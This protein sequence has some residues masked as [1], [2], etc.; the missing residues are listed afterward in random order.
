MHFL[1]QLIIQLYLQNYQELLI[2]YPHGVLS[3]VNYFFNILF[4]SIFI[5]IYCFFYQ[6]ALFSLSLRASQSHCSAQ[7]QPL[8]QVPSLLLIVYFYCNSNFVW[9][10]YWCQNSCSFLVKSDFFPE[11]VLTIKNMILLIVQVLEIWVRQHK[12]YLLIAATRFIDLPYHTFGA[13]WFEIS[14]QSVW[15]ASFVAM[16]FI[17]YPLS[18]INMQT[19]NL[20]L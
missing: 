6:C 12:E 7:Y 13:Y 14:H 17:S 8:T 5:I 18:F 2:I 11:K 15:L 10:S 9:E 4:Y 19:E 16:F 3:F 1:K 20:F